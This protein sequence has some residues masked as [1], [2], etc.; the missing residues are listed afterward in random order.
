MIKYFSQDLEN[1]SDAERLGQI[2]YNHGENNA[3]ATL[4]GFNPVLNPI[5]HDT[6]LDDQGRS[7]LLT[8]QL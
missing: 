7:I 6:I 5:I 3:S 2:I 8:E 1:I 4:M